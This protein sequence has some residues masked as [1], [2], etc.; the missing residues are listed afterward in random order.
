MELCEDN[1]SLLQRLV[2]DLREM[3][4]DHVALL[5]GHANLHLEVLEHSR[6]TSLIHLTYYFEH[7]QAL[8]PEPD[9][10][11][12]VYHDSGQLEVVELRQADTVLSAIPLYEVPGLT[13]KWQLNWFVSKWLGYCVAVG[14]RFPTAKPLPGD[15]LAIDLGR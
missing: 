12:R 15:E 4:G 2:P 10:V 14:Y 5:K 7:G 9:A 3:T 6:Y 1:Y 8:R 13:N 11:L